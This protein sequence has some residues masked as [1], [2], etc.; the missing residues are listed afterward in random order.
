MVYLTPTQ[1]YN[2]IENM[3]ITS[4]WFVI[5]GGIPKPLHIAYNVEHF[6]F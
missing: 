2:I 6:V 5:P 4:G 1:R 3:W